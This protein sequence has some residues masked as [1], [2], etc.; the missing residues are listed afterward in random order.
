M[1]ADK[2]LKEILKRGGTPEASP[3]LELAIMNRVNKIAEARKQAKAPLL[4]I[5][6]L[7]WFVLAYTLTAVPVLLMSFMLDQGY[8]FSSETTPR[9]FNIDPGAATTWLVSLAAF[10]LLFFFNTLLKKYFEKLSS[11]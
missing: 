10:W 9:P 11:K 7:A 1:Q 4:N 2:H 6:L 8:T 3:E 5:R